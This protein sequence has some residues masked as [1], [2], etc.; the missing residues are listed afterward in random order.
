MYEIKANRALG[1]IYLYLNQKPEIKTWFLPATI[2]FSVP[3]LFKALNKKVV[4]Y[5]FSFSLTKQLQNK[6][7]ESGILVTD[8]FGKSFESN[9]INELKNYY[10][11]VIYDRCLTMPVFVPNKNVNLILYSFGYEKPIDIG[12]G[13]FAYSDIQIEFNPEKDNNTVENYNYLELNW[14]KAVG[15]KA[16]FNTEILHPNKWIDTSNSMQI[17]IV[18]IELKSIEIHK[19]KALKN[20]IYSSYIPSEF[21]LHNEANNWRYNILVKDKKEAID[22]IFNQQLFC[23]SHYANAANYLQS[24]KHPN[25]EIIEHYIVNL[26]NNHKYTLQQVEKTAILI[27][28]LIDNQKIKIVNLI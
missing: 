28:K 7:K 27:K 26:F 2:C 18:N 19:E 6:A 15:N 9:E 8:Y 10:D 13:A 16:L 12:G 5:D 25:S 20:E 1:I 22:S 17:D 21:L 4:F 3:I 23:S 14:K 24:E 11:T